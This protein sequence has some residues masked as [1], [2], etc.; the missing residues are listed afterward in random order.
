SLAP[1]GATCLLH[2]F[3]T[4]RSSDLAWRAGFWPSPAEITL[5]MTTSSM[6]EGTRVARFTAS[7]MTVLPSLIASTFR[8]ARPYL[9]T[10][11][12]QAPAI[13]TSVRVGPPDGYEGVGR[14]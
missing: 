9:P 11:V 3:P 8:K 7:A 14:Y 10:G 4:R 2:S 12:R 5:P 1:P 13:T 6:S